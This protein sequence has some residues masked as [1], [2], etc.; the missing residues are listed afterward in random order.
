MI[1]LNLCPFAQRPFFSDTIRYVVSS[2]RGGDDLLKDLRA[3]LTLLATT[4]PQS[5]E[6]TLLIHPHAFQDFLDY[7]DFLDDAESLVN[8]LGLEGTLQIAS[9]HPAYQFAGTEPEDVENWTNRSPYP[10]LHLLR[11]ESINQAASDPDEL[12]RIPE[13]NIETMRRLG[14]EKIL[15]MLA[16]VR[17]PRS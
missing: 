10:I 4:A 3:E 8:Q 12:L 11:E 2:A 9:F 17:E 16:K 7:N 14:K 13:R 6:T 5:I 1:G 15:E